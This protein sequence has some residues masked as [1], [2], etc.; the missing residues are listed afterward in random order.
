M[1]EPGDF[2][3]NANNGVC[4]IAETI[5][6]DLIGDGNMK[7][8][9]LLVPVGESTARVYIPVDTAETRIRK[10]ITEEDAI[11]VIDSIPTIDEIR[12]ASEKERETKYKAA[13]RSCDPVQLF[14]IM[15]TLYHRKQTRIA[16]GKKSTAI[17]ERYYKMAENQLYAELAFVL[18]REKDDMQELI[19]ERIETAM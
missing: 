5:Q 9:F 4:R 19:R 7:P 12:I 15:K 18:G 16:Q 10:A 17:D 1:F 3:V 2:V 11:R 14:S 13:V 6:M 8:Y